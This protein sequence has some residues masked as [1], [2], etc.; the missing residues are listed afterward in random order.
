MISQCK[1]L[2]EIHSFKDAVYFIDALL[3]RSRLIWPNPPLSP[4][5]HSRVIGPILHYRLLLSPASLA[6]SST[7]A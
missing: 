3:L 6:Q 2:D 5:A 7:I 4:I 1:K